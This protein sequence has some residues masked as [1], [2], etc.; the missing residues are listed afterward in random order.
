MHPGCQEHLQT[1][2]N[3][4]KGIAG[5]C[6][7]VQCNAGAWHQSGLLDITGSVA[8]VAVQ[9]LL[10]FQPTSVAEKRTKKEVACH[11]G[12][13]SSVAQAGQMLIR[14]RYTRSI[15]S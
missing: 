9:P 2:H 8:G 13:H 6:V 7:R 10:A 15:S 1:L 4:W 11:T 5:H 12:E 3:D 14:A